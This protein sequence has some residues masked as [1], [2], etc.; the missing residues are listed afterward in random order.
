MHEVH[1]VHKKQINKEV[2]CPLSLQILEW[3]CKPCVPKS[4]SGVANLAAHLC[5]HLASLMHLHSLAQAA[6]TSCRYVHLQ[7]PNEESWADQH[8]KEAAEQVPI[9]CVAVGYTRRSMH[10][11]Q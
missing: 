3:R 5:D 4:W 8:E 11:L 10:A 6:C 1:L 2:R 7:A 9:A